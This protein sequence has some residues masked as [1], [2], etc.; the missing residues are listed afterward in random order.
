MSDEQQPVNIP[1][2]VVFLLIS[3]LAVRWFF[4]SSNN[5]EDNNTNNT[6]STTSGSFHRNAGRRVDE[7]H[8]E[9]IQAMFPQYGRREI[10]WDLMRNG[11]SVQATTE[12]IL[13]GRR[14]ER[15][16]PS[17]Q[18]PPAP[19]QQQQQQQQSQSAG[20]ARNQGVG[21]SSRSMQPSST[22]PDLIAR[23]NLS[24]KIS[25]GKGDKDGEGSR[26]GWSQNKTE[27]QATLQRRREEM[28][29]AARKKMMD[30]E[31]HTK[32]ANA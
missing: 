7:R 15:P 23:Y 17:F 10:I 3:A 12:R 16:P 6:S 8:V 5:N 21:G 25:S 4:F 9:Q 24:T 22:H 19:Q 31:A 32:K 28:I 27:R 1:Q 13:G 2:L 26:S 30:K 29:L 11:G 14:L 18:P 20:G